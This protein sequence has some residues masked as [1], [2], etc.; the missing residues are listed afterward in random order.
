[1]VPRC[2]CLQSTSDELAEVLAKADEDPQKNTLQLF[3]RKF[4]KISF[5]FKNMN[6]YYKKINS[7]FKYG[8]AKL[9]KKRNEQ[10]KK[11]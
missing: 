6:S 10:F 7:K 5:N 11:D 2:T 4:R 3:R 9:K 1:M 8:I